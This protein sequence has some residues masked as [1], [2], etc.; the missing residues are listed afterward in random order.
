[1]EIQRNSGYLG[2]RAILLLLLLLLSIIVIV[3][4]RR[5]LCILIQSIQQDIL[6]QRHRSGSANDCLTVTKV[7]M[8]LLLVMVRT[9]IQL[10]SH[11][12]MPIPR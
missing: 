5:L 1:M 7:G 3:F 4:E 10:N 8:T 6:M 9:A 12:Y 2:S 11:G